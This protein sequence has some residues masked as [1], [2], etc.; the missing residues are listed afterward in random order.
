MENLPKCVEDGSDLLARGQQLIAATVA[1]MAF[2]GP[3][4]GL[5]HAIAHTLGGLAEV[6][7][8]LGNSIIL[9][10]VVMFNLQEC[11]D[12]YA[13]VAQAMG[14]DTKGMSDTEAGEAAANA[15]WDL[16]RK[17]G[18]PQ[19]L[20]EVGVPEDQLEAIADMALSD[21]AIVNNPRMVMDSSEVLELLKEA[22]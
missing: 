7:H 14:I 10:H 18:V 21:G 5:A 4:V 22:Y 16:T 9:P 11:P 19:K 17:M 8:G 6:P 12:R 1:G 15:L 2:G 20:S 13:M 3:R